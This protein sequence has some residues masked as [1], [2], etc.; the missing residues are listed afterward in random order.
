MPSLHRPR[1]R[2]AAR[3]LA[4]RLLAAG[5]VA[6]TACSGESTGLSGGGPQNAVATFRVANG[7]PYSVTVLR[8]GTI[9]ARDIPSGEY[10]NLLPITAAGPVQLVLRRSGGA[11]DVP[12]TFTARE[13]FIH[14]VAATAAP[15]QPITARVLTDAG[16]TPQA[17]RGKLRLVHLAAEAPA[18]DFWYQA[19]GGG[20]PTRATPSP[21]PL[22]AETPYLAAIPG[23]WRVWVTPA[24]QA[25]PVLAEANAVLLGSGAVQ[26]V[27]LLPGSQGVT[28]RAFAD[29]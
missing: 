12:V 13:D 18:V 23:S 25:A 17:A 8:E 27:A 26:T 22:G 10:T 14:T 11:A 7:T 20:Q 9:V 3:L 4:A 24:G 19:P 1:R 6:A 16:S 29:R 15:G 2:L 5:L 21:F 28:L